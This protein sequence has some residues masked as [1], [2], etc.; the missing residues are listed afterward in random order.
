MRESTIRLVFLLAALWVLVAIPAL[1]ISTLPL[2]VIM[3][4]N[5]ITIYPH[6][7]GKLNYN[8]RY[9]EATIATG[10]VIHGGLGVRRILAEFVKTK[11]G[12]KI[13]D[14]FTVILIVVVWISAVYALFK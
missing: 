3:T 2:D 4:T 5:P 9:I 14:A 11:R 7:F 13:L 10:W 1:F 6:G 12:M 8:L